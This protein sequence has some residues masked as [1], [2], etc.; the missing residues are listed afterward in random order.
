MNEITKKNYIVI[1]IGIASILILQ[2]ILNKFKIYPFFTPQYSILLIPF[3]FAFCVSIFI[4]GKNEIYSSSFLILKDILGFIIKIIQSI[5][6]WTIQKPSQ[7]FIVKYDSLNR[8]STSFINPINSHSMKFSPSPDEIEL[9]RNTPY[10]LS[11][12]FHMYGNF[13][14]IISIILTSIILGIIAG[15]LGRLFRKLLKYVGVNKN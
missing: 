1:F 13:R 4:N 9:I 11:E 5:F 14:L 10:K 6:F 12:L 2:G 8:T 3:L 15:F 7:E